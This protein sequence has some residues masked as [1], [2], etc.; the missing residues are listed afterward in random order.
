MLA[1]WTKII[2]K[3][4]PANDLIDLS[5]EKDDYC[6]QKRQFSAEYA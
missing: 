5:A 3:D 2:E 4:L 1:R 6:P